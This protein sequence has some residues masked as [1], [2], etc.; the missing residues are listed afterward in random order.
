MLMMRRFGRWFIDFLVLPA[1]ILVYL[2][3]LFSIFM[4]LR[5]L[6]IS[7]TK[8]SI[9]YESELY[10][11]DLSSESLMQIGASKNVS[12]DKECSPSHV[13]F[14]TKSWIMKEE[15]EDVGLWGA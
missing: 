6:L 4:K 2:Q 10:Q 15:N 3:M 12:I 7:T 9:V 13:S 14:S 8:P 1:D 5:C 11:Y